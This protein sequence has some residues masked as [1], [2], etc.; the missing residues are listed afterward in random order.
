MNIE[1]L[2]AEQHHAESIAQIRFAL[3]SPDSFPIR[4]G[5]LTPRHPFNTL[6]LEYQA[7]GLVISPELDPFALPYRAFQGSRQNGSRIGPSPA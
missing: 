3:V 6:S 4:D 7:V 5:G 2:E 1:F